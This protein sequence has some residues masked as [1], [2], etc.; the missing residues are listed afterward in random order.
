MFFPSSLGC[1]RFVV[2]CVPMLI[3][4]CRTSTPRSSPSALLRPRLRRPMPASAV[5]APC[6]SKC[7]VRIGKE[8][9][10]GNGGG[11]KVAPVG[12][13]SF[14]VLHPGVWYLMTLDEST[15]HGRRAALD[16]LHAELC[17]NTT[18]WLDSRTCPERA[19]ASRC[20]SSSDMYFCATFTGA[21]ISAPRNIPWALQGV[22]SDVGF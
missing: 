1:G 16:G 8:G 18:S 6:A 3:L 7:S 19:C 10:V 9:G 5:P 15:F 11:K 22:L 14:S 12:Y 4:P 20:L 2:F 21:S 13:L 17:F